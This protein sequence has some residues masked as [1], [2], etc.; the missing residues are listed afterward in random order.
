MFLEQFFLLGV[1][2]LGDQ[3]SLNVSCL[4]PVQALDYGGQ[5]VAD[6]D[7]KLAS[8][9]LPDSA[10]ELRI[11]PQQVLPLSHL[12]ENNK[13]RHQD[14]G[15]HILH[16]HKSVFLYLFVLYLHGSSSGYSK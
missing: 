2:R 13:N 3:I 4:L 7:W 15:L 6:L 8:I 11:Q 9:Q 16:A 5:V 1:L 14:T 12:R 10:L